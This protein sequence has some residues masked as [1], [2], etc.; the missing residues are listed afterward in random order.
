M[1]IVKGYDLDQDDPD[2]SRNMPQAKGEYWCNHHH[3]RPAQHPPPRRALSTPP[4]T[5][6]TTVPTRPPCPHLRQTVFRCMR[7]VMLDNTN[8]SDEA[9]KTMKKIVK[10]FICGELRVVVL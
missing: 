6:S 4:T 7:F 2:P 10:K 3:Q 5:N 9:K 8:V 1:E